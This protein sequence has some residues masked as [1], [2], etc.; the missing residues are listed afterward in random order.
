MKRLVL[1]LVVFVAG[2]MAA[3]AQED[4][5]KVEIYGTYSLFVADIDALDNETLHG[6]GA[7]VQGNLSRSFGLVAEFSGDYG[8]SGPVTIGTTTIPKVD[9]TI[10]TFLFGPRFSYRTRPVTVFGHFL[11]GGGTSKVEERTTNI[12]I[13]NTEFA[14]A[15][16]GGL[17][18]NVSEHVAIRA[19]Q[20]D[21]LPIH[22][23]INERING[24]PDSWLHHLR[25]Q[26]GVVFKF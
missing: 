17:D 5:P 16:G 15:I 19:A 14:M 24:D 3:N 21:Y 6:W 8:S 9:T 2:T 12:N 1:L 18:V 13:S 23:D 11:V 25:Y 4:Y 10:Y 7:G 22:S 20:F 26:A